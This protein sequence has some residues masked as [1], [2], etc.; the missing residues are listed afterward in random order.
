M[1]DLPVKG[2]SKQRGLAL[3]VVLWMLTLLIIMASSFSLTIRREIA[4]LTDTKATVQ[5]MALAEAGINIAILQLMQNDEQTRWRSDNSLYEFMFDD[6]PIRVQITDESGKIDLNQTD[7][8]ALRGLL[9][10]NGLDESAQ[11]ALLAAI[12]DWR[13]QDDLP[14][15]SGGAE[16]AQYQ[17][18][19]LHY[20]PTNK[21]FENLEEL[22]MVLGMTPELYQ[23]LESLVTVY[24]GG[25]AVNAAKAS[26]EILMSLPGATPDLVDTY[27]TQRADNARSG[28]PEIAPPWFASSGAATQVYEIVA[29]AM[30]IEGV[31]GAI[32]AVIRKGQSRQGLPFTILKWRQG[33]ISGSLFAESENGRVIAPF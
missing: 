23:H 3:I 32:S 24:A 1:V 25:Q 21:P 29:E 12:N 27:L 33:G 10:S 16:K 9:N 30:P 20:G 6:V 19:G 4:I 2:N 14:S 15:P 28:L 8:L 22:Q 26:R 11:E 31:S 5:A 18:A 13:D 7:P 17:S